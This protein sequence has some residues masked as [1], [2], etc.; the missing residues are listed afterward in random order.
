[1]NE[2]VEND[3][4]RHFDERSEEWEDLYA[5]P[6]FQDRLQL[7]ING[8]K[9]TVPEGSRILDYGC[10]TGTIAL[11]LAECGYQVVGIDGGVG[12]GGARP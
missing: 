11:K 8:V 1:M 7:F 10:G 3:P 4:L 6:Q 12:H 9:E 5:R 2:G